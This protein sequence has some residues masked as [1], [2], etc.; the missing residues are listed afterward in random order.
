M[1]S[2]VVEN[3]NIRDQIREELRLNSVE[4]RPFF[5]PAN[6]MPVFYTNEIFPNALKLSKTGIN[7]PSYPDLSKEEVEF[8]CTVIKKIY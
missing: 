2:I 4:T 8:I 7:L 1:I 6:V 5:P 3:E